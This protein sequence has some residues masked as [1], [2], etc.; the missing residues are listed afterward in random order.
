MNKFN[1]KWK[2]IEVVNGEGDHDDVID[3]AVRTIAKGAVKFKEAV[4]ANALRAELTEVLE[5]AFPPFA[6]GPTYDLLRSYDITI[7]GSV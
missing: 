4:S 6:Q 2:V 5:K 3:G 7:T 1:V